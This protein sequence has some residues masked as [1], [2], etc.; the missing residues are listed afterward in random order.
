MSV[1]MKGGT[2]GI[3]FDAKVS[4]PTAKPQPVLDTSNNTM[5][6]NVQFPQ[7][8]GTHP[9]NQATP[10]FL[11]KGCSIPENSTDVSDPNA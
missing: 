3:R 5:T 2:S 1:V 11:P 8:R 10:D 4:M 7:K 9:A 6:S